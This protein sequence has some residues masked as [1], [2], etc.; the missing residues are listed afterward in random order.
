MSY[1]GWSNWETWNTYN[2]LSSDASAIFRAVEAAQGGEMEL[3]RHL[4]D[5]IEG[6]FAGRVLDPVGRG[7]VNDFA[8]A[9]FERIDFEELVQAL[10]PDDDEEDDEEEET[11]P[12]EEQ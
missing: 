6:I 7:L 11:E 9:C 4:D 10:A 8:T 1:N 5:V 3:R 12:D 2:W